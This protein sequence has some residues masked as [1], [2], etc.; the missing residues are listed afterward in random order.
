MLLNLLRSGGIHA[1]LAAPGSYQPRWTAGDRPFWDAAGD[2]VRG[3]WIA[4]GER[5]VDFAWPSLDPMYSDYEQTGNRQR[6]E[7]MYHKRRQ[8]ATTLIFAE[9]FENQ[10]RFIR[11]L[12]DAIDRLCDEPTWV[13][14][15]H[16]QHAID[17][18]SAETGNM[19]AW[20][21]YLFRDV[22]AF[23][24]SAAA[25]R[26]IREI[27]A[28]V[29]E[30]YL[31]RD[32]YWWMA[33]NGEEAG[34]WTT[35]CTSNC[36]G[37]VL[38]LETDV[39][40]R[41]RA[42]EKACRSLDRF[43]DAYKEDGGC[44]EGPMYWNFAAGCLF[45]SLEMLFEASG[46]AFDVFGDRAIGNIGAYIAT[47]HIH[48]LRFVN[49]ADSPPEVPVDAALLY[50]YGTRVGN[51]DMQALGAHLYRLLDRFDPEDTLRLKIYR[52]LA[53]MADAAT[54]RAHPG[55]EVVP[56][57]SY[58]SK[59]Q[60]VVAHGD[61]RAGQGLMLAAKGGHNNERHNHNDI[62][63]IVVYLD[64]R[65][66]LIDV[67]MKQYARDT[68]TDRR[69]D[70]WAMQSAYHNVPVVN[71]FMQSHGSQFAAHDAVFEDDE[72]FVRFGIDI[73]RAYPAAAGLVRW[74]RECTLARRA[75]T[76][77]IQDDYQFGRG[78]GRYQQRFMTVCRPRVVNGDVV[79]QFDADRSVVM[80]TVPMPSRVTL[81]EFSLRDGHLRHAWGGTLY[82][83]RL[84][85]D[86]AGTRGR[87][88]IVLFP[89]RGSQASTDSDVALET[90][91]LP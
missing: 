58:L 86:A 57:A 9:A 65:P 18:F 81:H 48:D 39:E 88:D 68:F 22:Q 82:Q 72:E 33:L 34:N 1:T 53:T 60:V 51:P 74:R 89:R 90:E 47:V 91:E 63:N 87:C 83:V 10:G 30:P 42:I 54:L 64:G 32:D 29:I 20:A 66:V 13:L 8:V 70:I 59:L 77:R 27:Q 79:L 56:R 36:L 14:P 24:A 19:L 41:A 46:G 75:G 26:A 84:H 5:Y 40:R 50:R 35:W 80:R 37:T 55:P 31:T 7:A 78:A 11:P 15:A 45:D 25:A 43:V 73:D 3:F 71:G 52:A 76:I 21:H 61:A 44:D 28:R 69:Y 2:A 38:L 4:R 23:T 12:L 6:F 67:G 49:F 62:G 16:E 17:L 85:F